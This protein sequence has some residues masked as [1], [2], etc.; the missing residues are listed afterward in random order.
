MT[1]IRYCHEHG[2]YHES[3]SGC[4]ECEDTKRMSA[5]F[6]AAPALTEEAVSESLEQIALQLW[7]DVRDI[8]REDLGK[9][10]SADVLE[11]T[12]RLT[13]ERQEQKPVAWLPLATTSPMW[14]YGRDALIGEYVERFGW[15]K[16][17]IWE[18]T[19]TRDDCIARG[20]T[21]WWPHLRDLPAPNAAPPQD[22]V[23]AM[24][25]EWNRSAQ[26]DGID[27]R[28]LKRLV[29]KT[30][31]VLDAAMQEPTK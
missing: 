3:E 23:L 22:S 19:W 17:T 31:K 4:P 10:E 28:E 26:G 30:E 1:N 20:A 6:G 15:K 8:D 16:V 11:Y 5:G 14:V 7:C 12:R 13:A 2:E 24:L 27:G 25:K 18:P 29:L 21:H 9:S